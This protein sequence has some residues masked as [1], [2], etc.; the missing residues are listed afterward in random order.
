MVC[1]CRFVEWDMQKVS[2]GYLSISND[3]AANGV[4]QIAENVAQ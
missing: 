3:Q 4:E 1:D 2:D